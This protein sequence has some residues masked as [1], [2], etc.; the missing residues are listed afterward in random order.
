MLEEL[1]DE[2]ALQRR[3]LILSR[4][5]QVIYHTIRQEETSEP[6][7]KCLFH[8]KRA[9]GVTLWHEAHGGAWLGGGRA[10]L[11]IQNHLP[12]RLVSTCL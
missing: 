11:L 7:C 4:R 10:V 8:A 2:G 5:L 6:D 1:G 3:A 9:E 12:A